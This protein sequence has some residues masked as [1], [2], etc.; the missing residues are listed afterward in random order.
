ML[1]IEIF[2]LLNKDEYVNLKNYLYSFEKFLEQ[3]IQKIDQKQEIFKTLNTDV[4]LENNNEENYHKQ[5]EIL[6]ENRYYFGTIFTSNFRSTFLG[7]IISNV[8]NLLKM[9]CYQYKELNGQ[10]FCLDDLK[11]T[12]DIEKAKIYLHKVSKKN[13]GEIDKWKELNDYKFVRNKI[14]HQ[15]GKIP[16]KNHSEISSIRSIEINYSGIQAVENTGEVNILLTNRKF[17]ETALDDTYI[18]VNNV[19]NELAAK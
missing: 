12:G 16:L 11:G 15:N 3:E 14:T 4:L 18:F 13:I 19:I 8:E 2:K 1:P 10:I 9:I 6:I 5:R 7:L 17:C